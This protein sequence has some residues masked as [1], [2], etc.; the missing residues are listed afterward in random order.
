MIFGNP[1]TFAAEVVV[2]P[3]PEFPATF[4]SNVAGRMRLIIGGTNV[5]NID[6]PRCVPRALSEHLVELSASAPALWH[7]LLEDVAP[8]EQLK[9]LDDALFLGGGRPE[10]ENCHSLIFLTNVSEA[11]DPIKGFALCHSPSEIYLLLKLEVS[12]P[13]LHF[14]VPYEEFAGVA[15]ALAQWVSEQERM[16]LN[17]PAV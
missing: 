14:V 8:H 16:L 13:V 10:L 17:G 9:L 3:G 15:A 12:G 6:E 2:E 4:G 5:G 7:P 1:L 11:F